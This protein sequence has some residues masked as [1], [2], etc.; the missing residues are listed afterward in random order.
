MIFIILIIAGLSVL[1]YVNK[2]N[3]VKLERC[4][5]HTWVYR[6]LGTEQEYMVC[7]KCG[8]LP[9]RDDSATEEKPY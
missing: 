1:Y 2:V 7:D 5:M 8:L 4:K 6:N 9:G 3:T